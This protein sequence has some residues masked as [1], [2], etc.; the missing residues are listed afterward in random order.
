MRI[1]LYGMRWSVEKFVV[2][3]SIP[4][5]V[6]FDEEAYEEVEQFFKE[7]GDEEGEVDIFEGDIEDV[8]KVDEVK[9]EDK[10]VAWDHNATELVPEIFE[11]NWEFAH[12]GG[13]DGAVDDLFEEAPF[14]DVQVRVF[15]P[16]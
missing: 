4:A 2:D 14:S 16:L 5:D 13:I 6:A 12:H 8:Y 10:L 11:E 1:E 9:E 15:Y 7:E 3:E